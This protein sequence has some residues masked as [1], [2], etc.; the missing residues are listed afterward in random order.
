MQRY[1]LNLRFATMPWLDTVVAPGDASL[2]YAGLVIGAG[3]APS[4][5]LAPPWWNPAAFTLWGEFFA[6]AGGMGLFSIATGGGDFTLTGAITGGSI[7]I[8]NF[9][10][11]AVLSFALPEDGH[12][13]LAVAITPDAFSAA[14]N[15]AAQTAASPSDHAGAAALILGG[16]DT[17]GLAIA[18]L[19]IL[20]HAASGA[21]LPV[22][23]ELDAGAGGT[24]AINALLFADGAAALWPDGDPMA[25]PG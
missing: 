6:G 25:W 5:A 18:H 8:T 11:G 14:V 21:L 19:A 10:S 15:G 4:I 13:R 2:S 16:G 22:L 24:P 9:A 20:P 23:S 7:V 1:S 3:E 17:A 12:F